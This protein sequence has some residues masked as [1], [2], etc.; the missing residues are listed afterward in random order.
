MKKNIFLTLFLTLIVYCVFLNIQLH[1]CKQ[2][3]NKALELSQ[4][5]LDKWLAESQDTTTTRQD[6]LDALLD[7]RDYH[8]QDRLINA[9]N[10]LSE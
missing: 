5:Y 4:F 6:K 8:Q 3:T 9:V 10:N 7:Y 1:K 2:Q